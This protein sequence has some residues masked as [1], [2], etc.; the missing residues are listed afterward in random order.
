MMTY[1][2][3]NDIDPTEQHN[4][5]LY[6]HEQKKRFHEPIYS[7][8][9]LDKDDETRIETF[10]HET[11]SLDE[12]EAEQTSEGSKPERLFPAFGQPL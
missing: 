11:S 10:N 5:S 3:S 4:L 6:R 1:I 7:S 12:D 9:H 8:H 2:R